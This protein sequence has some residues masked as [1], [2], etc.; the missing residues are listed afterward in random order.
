LLMYADDIDG[1]VAQIDD[2]LEALEY[3]L[4]CAKIA[5]ES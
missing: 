5:D 4:P 1:A 3:Q 2:M